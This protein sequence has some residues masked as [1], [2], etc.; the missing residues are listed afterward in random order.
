MGNEEIVGTVVDRE[1]SYTQPDS[2]H[3]DR[4]YFIARSCCGVRIG[5]RSNVRALLPVLA[6]LIPGCA[7][8]PPV[9]VTFAIKDNR[10]LDTASRYEIAL[11]GRVL[12]RRFG[13]DDALHLLRCYLQEMI[14]MLATDLVLVHA[15]VVGWRGRALLL[16]G[17]SGTG[18]STLAMALV[19]L[20]AT[21][22]SDELA[23][24]DENAC[25]HPYL[26]VPRLRGLVGQETALRVRQLISAGMPAPQ[27]LPVSLVLL[28]HY[29]EEASCEQRD[30]TCREI[31]FGLIENTVAIR[32]RPE[33]SLR[34][35]K[36]VSTRARGVLARRGDVRFVASA[37]LAMI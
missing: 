19:E 26:R 14:A 21:Y 30:M 12:P 10:D 29:L 13:L 20:G 31:L 11:N 23:V 34:V 9:Q 28:T 17:M 1:L 37:V 5:L 36:E 6:S 24:I 27:P 2:S 3:A 32:N 15:A 33:L 18:K 22:Y 35:L 8:G 25:V 7:S 16:P 4:E